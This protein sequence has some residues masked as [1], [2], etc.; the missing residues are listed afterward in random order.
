MK[1]NI[2]RKT[3][4]LMSVILLPAISGCSR[5]SSN[6]N[7]TKPESSDSQAA[8]AQITETALESTTPEV[9]TTSSSEPEPATMVEAVD[10]T[11]IYESEKGTVLSESKLNEM[12]IEELA[13][14]IYPDDPYFEG[15]VKYYDRNY[16]AEK[17]KENYAQ[18]LTYC[19]DLDHFSGY[20]KEELINTIKR[21]PNPTPAQEDRIISLYTE[22]SQKMNNGEMIFHEG[23][24]DDLLFLASYRVATGV[25]EPLMVALNMS[26]SDA[27][28]KYGGDWETLQGLY[29]ND[30]T[31]EYDNACV[32]AI[33]SEALINGIL[34][35]TINDAMYAGYIDLLDSK[36]EFGLGSSNSG[37]EV[38]TTAGYMMVIAFHRGVTIDQID[39]KT[40]LEFT[41]IPA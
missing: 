19:R 24:R 14:I 27:S 12:S 2:A 25:D 37:A 13:A 18:R 28:G 16:D 1:K 31:T 23:L 7:E 17:T 4:L 5:S 39:G 26:A 3:A 32:G 8:Y 36:L 35:G 38:N 34:D 40:W 20:T 11:T 6:T 29:W 22:A 30:H 15:F 21:Y 33:M 41:Y 9:L 10:S